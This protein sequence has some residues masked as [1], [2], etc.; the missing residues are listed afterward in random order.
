MELK[1]SIVQYSE[2][3]TN[4]ENELTTI[5]NKFKQQLQQTKKSLS[6]KECLIE[7]Q[8]NDMK[9]LKGDNI[10]LTDELDDLKIEFKRMC[11]M[12]ETNNTK[13]KY[14]SD[15]EILKLESFIKEL[16]DSIEELMEVKNHLIG[17]NR[18]LISIL[19]KK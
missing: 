15:N 10:E 16:K 19:K 3:L 1:A 7:E 6:E 17:E 4:R 8:Q 12:Y 14:D 11:E 18:K 5:C 13:L 9:K 2:E